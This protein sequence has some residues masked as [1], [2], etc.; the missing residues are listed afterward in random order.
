MFRFHHSQNNQISYSFSGFCFATTL[1][2]LVISYKIQSE[3]QQAAQ[4][5][6]AHLALCCFIQ[7]EFQL[8]TSGM[9]GGCTEIVLSLLML[10]RDF[11]STNYLSSLAHQIYMAFE[12]GHRARDTAS[13]PI[14]ISGP[15]PLIQ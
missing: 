3:K 15:N 14:I 8:Y 6:A 5:N 12:Y 10:L 11:I 9:A 7:N 13:A 1:P 2:N 4:N